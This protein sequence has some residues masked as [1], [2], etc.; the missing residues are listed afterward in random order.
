MEPIMLNG[1]F[2]VVFIIGL[3]MMNHGYK[4]GLVTLIIGV[5]GFILTAIAGIYLEEQPS[6]VSDEP[7]KIYEII[8]DEKGP[9][10]TAYLNTISSTSSY[11]LVVKD[12][13]GIVEAYKPNVN[14]TKLIF[15]DT[16]CVKCYKATKSWWIFKSE[17]DVIELHIPEDEVKYVK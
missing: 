13:D 17:T 6:I 7:H 14:Q 9:D 3:F 10:I 12:E 15:D 16:S 4:F 8:P 2:S 1:I 5:I 11:S